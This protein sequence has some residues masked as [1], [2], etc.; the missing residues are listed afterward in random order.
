MILDVFSNL[1]NSDCIRISWM[2][3]ICILNNRASLGL[4]LE[5]AMLLIQY[6]VYQK[7]LLEQIDFIQVSEHTHKM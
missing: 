6:T 1:N 7:S 3:N 5:Q 2:K 4:F